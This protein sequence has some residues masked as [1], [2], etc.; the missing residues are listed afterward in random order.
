ML[1]AFAS[2]VILWL[3]SCKFLA[4]AMGSLPSIYFIQTY[5]HFAFRSFSTSYDNSFQLVFYEEEKALN[6]IDFSMDSIF[7]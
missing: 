2:H 3:L 6:I 7:K 4:C 5:L 1:L